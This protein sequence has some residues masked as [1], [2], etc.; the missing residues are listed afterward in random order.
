MSIQGINRLSS[1]NVPQEQYADSAK[2]EAAKSNPANS[3][4]PPAEPIVSSHKTR[5][6]KYKD[7]GLSEADDQLKN[8]LQPLGT[9]QKDNRYGGRLNKLKLDGASDD[10]DATDAA[11]QGSDV[12]QSTLAA[13]SDNAA[14]IK[15]ANRKLKLDNTYD[16]PAHRKKRLEEEPTDKA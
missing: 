2:Q 8:V 10:P 11:P 3:T 4:A 7:R 1:V 13:A 12:A 5:A 15:P 9:A 16:I 14:N 6:K